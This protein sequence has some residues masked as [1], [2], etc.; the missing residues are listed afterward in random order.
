MCSIFVMYLRKVWRHPSH[1]TNIEEQTIQCPEEQTIQCPEEQTIQCPEEQTIQ[2]P[3]KQT[4]QCP[5][6]QTIQCPKEK[7]KKQR[8]LYK[9]L[10]TKVK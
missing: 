4:I 10:H 2:C 3:E 9:T 5:E 6:E 7:D 1:K 8:I